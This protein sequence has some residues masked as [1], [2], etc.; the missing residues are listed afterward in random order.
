MRE[1]VFAIPGDPDTLTGGYIYDKRLSRALP[2]HGWRVAPLRLGDGF[3][4][5]SAEEMRHAATALAAVPADRPLVVDGLAFGA[6]DPA[7]VV[8]IEVPLVALVHHPLALEG[9]LDTAATRAVAARE[10]ANLAAAAA[11]VVTSPHTGEVL[12]RDYAV[13]PVRLTVALPGIDRPD[14]PAVGGAPPHVLCVGSLTARK[15]HDVLLRALADLGDLDWRLSLV[16]GAR[17]AHVAAALRDLVETLSLRDRVRFVGELSATELR[18]HY[19]GATVFAL[20]SRYEGYGMVFA[21]ALS[22]G[23]PIVACRAG[24]VSDTVPAEAGLLVPPDDPA[25]FAGALRRVLSDPAC[26]GKLSAAA[27]A[28]GRALPGWP[29]TAARVA[30]VLA[31]L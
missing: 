14:R 30:A 24:A 2:E 10:R 12:V 20:A 21:E 7:A 15:A 18:A 16:G 26:H 5:P 4:T 25:A 6:L 19:A 31:R 8:G 28:A 9:G 13:P 3:P 27:W 23:L 17:D 22:H 11:V 29:D 1:V